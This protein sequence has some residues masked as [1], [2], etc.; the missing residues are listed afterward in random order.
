MP[1]FDNPNGDPFADLNKQQASDD[2][3]IQQQQELVSLRNELDL[4]LEAISE[5]LDNKD[6]SV[7][8]RVLHLGSLVNQGTKRSMHRVID[9]AEE[10]LERLGEPRQRYGTR[11]YGQQR[12]VPSRRRVVAIN[13]LVTT[14]VYSV[15]D[16]TD[17]SF[18][19]L[20]QK[21]KGKLNNKRPEQTQNSSDWNELCSSGNNGSGHTGDS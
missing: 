15:P 21:C 4:Q 18:D 13:Q 1:I 20:C 11:S 12:V 7:T 16:T 14:P 9:R 6:P 19:N 17:K 5:A 3:L 2:K 10:R 8:K